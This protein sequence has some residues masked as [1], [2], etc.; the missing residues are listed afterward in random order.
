[1]KKRVL[2]ITLSF[3]LASS[4]ISPGLTSALGIF[5][6]TSSLVQ[7]PI[8]QYQAELAPG[9]KEKH[10]SFKGKNGKK[11]ESFV[12]DVDVHNPN[13]S[14]EAGTPNDD[15]AYGLQ[16]VRKQAEAANGDNHKVVAAVNADF[17]NMATGEPN[18]IVL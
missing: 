4:I 11:I 18:G 3:A 16:P 17:Y 12:V 8:N 13:V 2:P 1:M 5:D 7:T 15:E 6:L 14:I 10:Y 9:V